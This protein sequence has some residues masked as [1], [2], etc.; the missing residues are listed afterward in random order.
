MGT[1]PGL[2]CST[3][4]PLLVRT[5]D[6]QWWRRS[7]SG[8]GGANLGKFLG[9]DPIA[10]LPELWDI[11]PLAAYLGVGRRFVYR[12]TEQR[13]IRFVSVGGKLRFNSVDVAA[14]LAHESRGRVRPRSEAPER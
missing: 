2:G 10:E 5:N 3:F 13:R 7:A 8:I 1:R 14:Y 4:V 11:D 12:L 6:R 9:M